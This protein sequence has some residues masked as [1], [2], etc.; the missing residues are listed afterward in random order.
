MK[1]W[2]RCSPSLSRNTWTASNTRAAPPPC[3]ESVSRRQTA[4]DT[5]AP[6]CAD[7]TPLYLAPPPTH[8]RSFEHGENK[9]S[10]KDALISFFY[11]ILFLTSSITS[12]SGSE[13]GRLIRL[14]CYLKGR[15]QQFGFPVVTISS[16]LRLQ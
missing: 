2:P 14:C 8:R 4:A 13:P 16:A 11:T 10:D 7:S 1:S 9:P 6:S 12:T 5:W 3:I 15:F